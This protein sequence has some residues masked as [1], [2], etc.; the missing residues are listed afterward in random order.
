MA[1]DLLRVWMKL[2]NI[3][4]YDEGDGWGDA[5]PYLWTVF[6]K[7]DGDGVALTDDL[8]LSG[9][10]T[11]VTTPGSHGNLGTSDVNAGDDVQ[12]PSAIGEWSQF[13]KP[14]PV[15][16]DLRPIV[17]DDLGGVVGVVVVLMEEDNVTDDGAQAGHAAL[18]SAVQNALDDI[19]ATLGF[20]HADITD[21]D[22]NAYLS[23][24]QKAISD[25]VEAE[26]NFFENIWSFLNAD[27]LIGSR[28]FYF[29]HDR[30]AGG[31]VTDFS[32]RWRNEG[33]WE[34]YGRVNASVAC[35]AAAAA[36]ANQILAEL[37][38]PAAEQMRAF[39][40]QEFR[41]ENMRA[42]W[43]MIDRN[44]P[45]LASA[46]RS[47][48]NLAESAES[49]FKLA[50]QLHDRQ[51]PI[52]DE[53]FDHAERILRRLHSTGGRKARLDA[54]RMLS[55]L[56]HMRGKTIEGTAELVESVSTNR[57]PRPA[58]DVSHLIHAE[59]RIPASLKD[60]KRTKT[61]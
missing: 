43:S 49:L 45:Q 59:T 34:L 13:L 6:F 4:C 26:Q 56:E 60:G 58:K 22:I 16:S 47:D 48:P 2:D 18:N 21:D 33:D 30:L 54:S 14:I 8:K 53:E 20:G 12:I 39:R 17:G 44:A 3:R 57:N 55:L 15:P 24:M 7:I 10:A 36:D 38:G 29:K 46:I 41:H 9:K 31:E 32:Q 42:W 28:V 51:R 27:D 35:T 52:A 37:F 19:I 1:R 5:E 11:V 25:A 23:K 40:D 61:P 50:A